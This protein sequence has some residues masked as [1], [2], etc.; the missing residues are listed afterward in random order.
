MIFAPGGDV[1]D[2]LP[3]ESRQDVA[4]KRE[5]EGSRSKQEKAF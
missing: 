3:T 5:E 4:G 2:A 1:K